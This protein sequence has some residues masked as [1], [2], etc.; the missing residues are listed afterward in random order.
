MIA[1]RLR[2]FT[3]S[4][5]LLAS[6]LIPAVVHAQTFSVARASIGGDGGTDYLTADPATGRVFVSRGTHVMVV[7]GATGKC[8]ATSPTRRACTAS[9][10]RRRRP[11]LHDE[12]RRLDVDDVRP[13]DAGA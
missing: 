13:E 11:R 5:A 3:L 12:R 10:S 8:S 9:R 6:A 2:F 4:T 7:D 1:H